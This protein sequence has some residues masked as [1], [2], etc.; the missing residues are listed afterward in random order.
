VIVP[1]CRHIDVA[2]RDGGLA[3][4]DAAGAAVL[5]VLSGTCSRFRAACR[6]F[7]LHRWMSRE[8][9]SA[10]VMRYHPRWQHTTLLHLA[11]AQGM[12]EVAVRLMQRGSRVD[13]VDSCGRTPLEEARLKNQPTMVALLLSCERQRREDATRGHAERLT[14]RPPRADARVMAG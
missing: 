11:A 8:S 12:E 2:G 3:T 10:P 13:A 6:R 5:R 1:C 9:L 4:E 7:E 14:T